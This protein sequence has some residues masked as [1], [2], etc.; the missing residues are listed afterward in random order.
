MP[1]KL[2]KA[3]FATKI[4]RTPQ[5]VSQLINEGRIVL[6]GNGRCAKV[7]VAESLARLRETDV[8]RMNI[9]TQNDSESGDVRRRYLIARAKR[10]SHLAKLAEIELKVA[11]GQLVKADAV[12]A[13]WLSI[14]A[15]IRARL[16]A[17]PSRLAARAHGARTRGELQRLLQ[18]GI[19]EA[20][21]ELA[22]SG[23]T[24][25]TGA[26]TERCGGDCDR[27]E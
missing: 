6:A 18:A 24:A 27:A 16:L 10:E 5:R 22:E 19:Y 4:G 17:L 14:A 26:V 7:M 21:Q 2:S 9:A 8:C 13:E 12:L 11:T 3:D 23:G 15:N 20:L 1:E 25:D